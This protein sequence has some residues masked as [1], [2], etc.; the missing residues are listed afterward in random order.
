VPFH[1]TAPLRQ[2]NFL[3]PQHA[4]LT[5]LIA[6]HSLRTSH[7]PHHSLCNFICKCSQQS[8]W[9][10]WPLEIWPIGCL[11]TSATNYQS[12]LRKVSEQRKC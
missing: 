11:K 10:A 6:S 1:L 12:T 3:P 9:T 8:S 4:P 2:L 7:H 5:L